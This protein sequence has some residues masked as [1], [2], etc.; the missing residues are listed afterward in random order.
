M[1]N[2]PYSFPPSSPIDHLLVQSLMSRL[3][4]RPHSPSSDAPH[5]SLLREI[6]PQ[7]SEDAFSASDDDLIDS[8]FDSSDLSDGSRRRRAIAMEEAKLEKEIIRIVRSGNA[9]EVLKA[10]SGQSVSVGEHN[11]CIGVHE[12]TGGHYRV[13]EWH[14]HI[15]MFDEEEGFSAEYV[16]GNYFERLQDKKV[17][18]NEENEG[19]EEDQRSGSSGLKDLIG[20][21]EDTS[22]NGKGRVLHRNSLGS[23]SSAK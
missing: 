19:E 1:A 18:T 23:G 15:M 17:G 8:D 3:Q 22:S 2:K 7:L 4:L 21:F 10:N 12:E 6:F 16:Y 9:E 13:W 11:V 20:N 14:G 5:N